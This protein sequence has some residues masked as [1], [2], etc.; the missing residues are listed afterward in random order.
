LGPI[1]T[2]AGFM[3]GSAIVGGTYIDVVGGGLCQPS[4]TLFQ[5]VVK[6]D[7]EIVERHNHGMRS[8]YYEYGQDAMIYGGSAD[9]KFRN[10]SEYPVAIVAEARGNYLVYKIYG[11]PLPEGVTIGLASIKTGDLAPIE[12]TKEVINT[13]IAPGESKQT[14]SPI[15][16]STWETYKVYYKNGV[17]FDRQYLTYSRYPSVARR[18]EFGPSLPP[19]EVPTTTLPP[20]TTTLPPETTTTTT[21]SVTTTLP[22][23]DPVG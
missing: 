7:L 10:N 6:S 12:T 17:E 8:S 19:T 15:V 16:G 9:F 14:L 4:T 22:S 11:Q 5:A 23:A 20:E 3:S 1:T 21:E 18:I 2:Q 13:E